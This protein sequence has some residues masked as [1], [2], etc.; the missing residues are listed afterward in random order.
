MNI[1]YHEI[2]VKI[3]KSTG[4]IDKS[5]AATDIYRRWD[6]MGIST[7]GDCAGATN[8]L[9]TD[10]SLPEDTFPK[11]KASKRRSRRL[12]SLTHRAQRSAGES[13]FGQDNCIREKVPAAPCAD[14]PRHEYEWPERR[15]EVREVG[16][17]IPGHI[18]PPLASPS[19]SF[20]T[21]ATTETRHCIHIRAMH[22][23]LSLK[24]SS[25]VDLWTECR[26]I[27]GV[28]PNT[29]AAWDRATGS[30]RCLHL[31]QYFSHYDHISHV[32]EKRNRHNILYMLRTIK[33]IIITYLRHRGS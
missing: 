10:T 32:K 30:Q 20:E 17:R 18:R 1:I 27:N 22:F 25:Y 11:W 28:I 31:D 26:D 12:R 8:I 29:S 14:A 2:F 21:F 3:F 23:R 5:V 24:P 7:R 33:L 4:P 19:N 16:I 15:P 9:R 6:K 13:G